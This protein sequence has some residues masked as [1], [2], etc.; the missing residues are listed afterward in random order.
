MKDKAAWKAA[1]DNER[2]ALKIL[3]TMESADSKPTIGVKELCVLV[4]F[5]GV[6]KKEISKMKVQ[7]MKE[8]YNKI[9][10]E[11]TPTKKFGKWTGAEEEELTQLMIKDVCIDEKLLGKERR[12]KFKEDNDRVFEMVKK[13]RQGRDDCADSRRFLL[14]INGHVNNDNPIKIKIHQNVG[15]CVFYVGQVFFLIR[16][17]SCFPSPPKPSQE[18]I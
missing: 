6:K 11:N 8:R 14:G 9:K 7:E 5:Y 17:K 13:E 12:I 2:K 1:E 10:E 4:E 18:V 16:P 15:I 3:E